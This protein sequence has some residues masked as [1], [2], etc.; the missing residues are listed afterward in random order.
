[1]LIRDIF[2]SSLIGFALV[3]AAAGTIFVATLGLC[4]VFLLGMDPMTG[5]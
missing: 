1:M 2:Y 3:S 5:Q 4:A